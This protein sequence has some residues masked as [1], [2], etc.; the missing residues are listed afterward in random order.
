MSE[1]LWQPEA[2]VIADSSVSKLISALNLKDYDSLHQWSINN[3]DEFWS[4]VW[5]LTDIKGEMGDTANLETNDFLKANFFPNANLNVA[6]NL[7]SNKLNDEVAIT[8]VL[9]NGTKVEI[10]WAQL[11]AE[12][13]GRAHV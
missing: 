9:E 3:L 4:K 2:K 1:Q 12:E 13:I 10:S 5:Q 8:S 7:I 6:E 11:R